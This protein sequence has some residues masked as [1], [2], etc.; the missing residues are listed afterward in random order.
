MSDRNLALDL[1]ATV[2][3]RAEGDVDLLGGPRD[4]EGWLAPRGIDEAD[5]SLRLADFRDL[6][7]A[8]LALLAA[9]AG[10]RP[11]PPDAVEAV[12]AAT[13]AAPVS[14]RLRV[15]PPDVRLVEETSAS[16][17]ARA[18]ASIARDAI[19]VLG[20]SDRDRLRRCPASACGRF[21]V[22]GRAAQVWCSPDCGNRVRV[23]RHHARRRTG[24][25]GREPRLPA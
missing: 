3:P 24:V 2:S 18:F 8:I 22:L 5:L 1:V 12:N 19:E 7:A 25:H 17:A 20:G 23:A 6:R 11:L 9:A 10:G 14:V 21:F 13:A 16:G 15:E 4:L